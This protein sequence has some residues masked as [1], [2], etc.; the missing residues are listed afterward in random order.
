ME[1]GVINRCVYIEG[2]GRCH[3]LQGG[4]GETHV[5]L[6]DFPASMFSP[7]TLRVAMIA[8]EIVVGERPG[9]IL[10]SVRYRER[11]A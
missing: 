7:D 8:A 6:V 5:G 11:A 1:E 3:V 4:D 10:W 9:R 2:I